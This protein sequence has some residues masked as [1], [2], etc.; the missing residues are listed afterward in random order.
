[1]SASG[2]RTGSD[3]ARLFAPDAPGPAA[4]DPRWLYHLRLLPMLLRLYWKRVRSQLAQEA[5]AV[6]GIAVGVGLIFA[7]QIANTSVPASVRSLFHELVG[8]ASIE[9]GAR[10]PE[11]FSQSLVARIGE[12]PGVFGAAG[13]LESRIT[14]IGPRGEEALTLFGAEPAIGVIGGPLVRRVSLRQLEAVAPA[15]SGQSEGATK[16]AIARIPTIALPQGPAQ[17]IGAAAGQMLVVHTRGRSILVLCARVFGPNIAGAASQ[18]PV[19]IAPLSS[20]QRITGLQGRLTRVMVEPQPGRRALADAS[21]GQIAGQR[22]N[23]RP[24]SSEVSL[25]EEATASQSQ[26]A[27]VFTVLSLLVGLLFA[28]NAMLL[29]LPTRRGWITWLRNRGATR[30]DLGRLVLIEVLIVGLIASALGLLLG[31]LLSDIVFGGVPRYLTSGFP[32]GNQRVVSA[33]ALAVS[34]GAGLIA[35]ALAAGLP[36]IA[37]LRERPLHRPGEQARAPISLGAISGPAGLAL[38]GAALALTIAVVILAPSQSIFA[39]VALVVALIFLLPTVVPW[40]VARSELLALRLRTTAA[41]AA[42]L[43][44]RA[45][46]LRATAVGAI[47]AVALFAI[48]A[49]GGAADDLRRGVDKTIKDVYGEATVVVT[50]ASFRETAFPVQ[51]FASEPTLARLRAVDGVSSVGALHETFVDA[52]RHRLFVIAKPA[53]DPLPISASQLIEGSPARVAALLRAGGWA[54]LTS[55]V[56]REWHLHLGDRFTL[57]TPA[58]YAHFRLAATIANYGWPP[59]AIVI[60]PL[61]YERLWRTTNVTA[62]NVRFRPGISPAR[63]VEAVRG[64]L[65]GSA[66]LATGRQSVEG[67]IQAATS[68][69]LAQLAGIATLVLIAALFAVIGAMAGSVWQR[70]SR[71]ATLKRLGMRRWEIVRTIYFETAVV[72]II[73]CLLGLLFGLGGQPIATLYVRDSTG[74]PEAYAPALLL[75]LRTLLLIGVLSTLAAGLFGYAITRRIG[76][77]SDV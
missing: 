13:V 67:D 39:F 59:G 3:P 6:L 16:R 68:Q 71:L 27:T 76:W 58:G 25:L 54:A 32:I 10:S 75:A 24:S 12:A 7:V 40:L 41:Y 77:E 55:T 45:A 29:T 66:L 72:V 60:S 18:S 64:A 14:L 23:V 38:S 74:V 43:E 5:L 57:P 48:V 20:V 73:G 46:P 49:L 19:A 9:V 47:G 53:Q 70:R 63:A 34:I 42:T 17:A 52:N 11:G 36:A 30:K 8:K 69:A 61:E 26:A 37:T 15:A 22:L 33:S 1:V 50:P 2:L 21:L 51:P 65:R 35:T 56:A 44:L 62:F 31:Y 4:S 28:Y